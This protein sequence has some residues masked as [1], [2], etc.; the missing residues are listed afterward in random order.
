MSHKKVALFSAAATLAIFATQS[1][2]AFA[3]AA[4][5]PA[6][7]SEV[8]V[9]AQK[10]Q[11]NIQ[12]VGMSIQAASGDK[13]VKLG[14]TDTESL[15]K[16][17]PGF[18]FTPTYYGTNVFTI[19]GVG[20]QDTSLAGSPTVSVYLDEAPIP[21]SSLTNGATL[22]VQRVEVLKGPQ[23]TLFGNNAT[24]GAINYIANKPTDTFH[25]G[26]TVSYG[27][28]SD[29]DVQ[30]YVSGPITEGLDA[31]LALR[32]E[33]SGAWQ[34]GYG[35]Q[36]GQ[37]TG[38]KDFTNGRFSLSWKPND[39][40]KALLTLN[41]WADRGYNQAS[42]LYGIAELS[43]IAPLAPAIANYPIAPHNDQA[44]GWNSCVNTSPF[45]PIAGQQFGNL[46]GT[47]AQTPNGTGP[48]AVPGAPYESMGPGSVV[49]AGGQPTHCIP[50]KKNNV[51]WSGSLRMDYD[52]GNDMV[53][54]SLSEFQKFNRTAGI[55][56]SAMPI[57]DYQ[58]YQR[59]RIDSAYTELR[60]AGK[61]WGKGNW[62]IGANYEW[63]YTWDSFLQTYNASSAS[64][65]VF[66]NPNFLANLY[67]QQAFAIQP[68][69]VPDG[70]GGVKP[71]G[72]QQL[73]SVPGEC[74]DVGTLGPLGGVY[75][76][77]ATN[78][79]LVLGPTKPSDRQMTKTYAVY[80]SGEY[81]ILDNLTLLGGVRYTEEDKKGG[82]C[83]NDGGDGSWAQVAYTLQSF[84]T[85]PSISPLASPPGTCASTGPGPT[86]NT[87]GPRT[88]VGGGL[89]YAPLHQHNIAWRAGLNW[90]VTP[91]DLLYVNISQGY[92]GG[93]FPTVAL[94]SMVQTHPVVQ[95]GLLS[96]EAGFKTM[97]FDKQLT[98]NGAGFYY[99]Y[100]DKQIL[101]AV[102]DQL[103]GA[104]P[105]LVNVPKSR[106]MGFEL[107][108]VYTPEWLKGFTLIPAVSYQYSEVLKTS[109]NTCSPP[110]YQDPTLYSSNPS[111]PN[112]L[113]GV[114]HCQA[115][116]YYGFDGFGQ[117]AD[118]T[119][120]RFPSAPVWQA[121]VDGEYRWKL[122]DDI[123]AFVGFDLNYVS[124]TNSFFY[125][126]SPTPAFLNV[127]SGGTY[128][129]FGGY[130]SAVDPN[131]GLMTLS[132]TPV[133]P[134]PLNHPNDTFKVP[135][136]AL[137][138]LRAGVEMGEWSVQVWGRNVTNKYYWTGAA[139]VND[140]LER[141]TGMPT[142]VGF[143]VNW[144]H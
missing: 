39:K 12:N 24:G 72:G 100:T 85:P 65:T 91:D 48:N 114:I 27:T 99:D 42:Q 13:L 133:G 3:Q 76:G 33:S 25:A 90:K 127:G 67:G 77:G 57:Q 11:E 129:V 123:T 144:R 122:H 30:G 88:G 142:T 93:S 134:L 143:T 56:G 19:R 29:T 96:Y 75:C 73:I 116:H 132:P 32:H 64:P 37:S 36:S 18:Q 55:D 1:G 104:L 15:S 80:L 135:G 41:G 139:H 140:E 120:E 40:F 45:D 106:V 16:I 69:F 66:L 62:I 86:Y 5:G 126:R 60:L 118:F 4:G 102:A 87:P 89:I 26:G 8:I 58:S 59:G 131:T 138:D 74:G 108:A 111:A 117:Y 112:F 43:A 82:V 53:L 70:H 81:P 68:G 2:V 84:Y 130:V 35:P 47:F 115:E 23:G 61:W 110:P 46:W 10:R 109:R 50:L 63:D 141:Y 22:D 119:G 107:N 83:G 125:N 9:T 52:L 103:Y 97:W 137:L 7:V 6:S 79:A 38:G 105:L 51:Y 136:H 113:P 98:F 44:A 17:V 92:K 121:S 78:T 34:K 21:F 14:I 28:F 71:G 124:G 101:G 94:A 54:T 49:Q 31:R 20:F 95:E 128:P